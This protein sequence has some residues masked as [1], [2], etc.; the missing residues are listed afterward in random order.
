LDQRVCWWL[1]QVVSFGVLHVVGRV[2]LDLAGG[3]LL[4]SVVVLL[5]VSF[6]WG[7]FVW[8]CL[9][10]VC[11][12]GLGQGIA[13]CDQLFCCWWIASHGVHLCFFGLLCVVLVLV[14]GLLSWISGS[15]CGR[16]CLFNCGPLCVIRGGPVF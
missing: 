15:S 11:V 2:V 1:F 13:F 14:G 8:R 9:A 3:W 12:V 7:P 16:Q 10:S 5:I 4:G 6:S